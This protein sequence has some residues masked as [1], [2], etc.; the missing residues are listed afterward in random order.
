MNARV[1]EAKDNSGWLQR[2]S[3]VSLEEVNNSVRI[4][5]KAGFC[6]KFLAFAGPGSLVAVGYVDP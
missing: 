3:N 1:E 2:S 6:R 5:S 4:P